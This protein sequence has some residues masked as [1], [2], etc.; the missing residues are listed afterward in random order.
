MCRR[1]LPNSELL[2]YSS[3]QKEALASSTIE[4][5]VATADELVRFQASRHTDREPV[6]EVANYSA[7]LGLGREY[8][9]SK[10]LTLNLILKLHETLMSGVRGNNLAGKFK[11]SQNF[12][13]GIGKDATFTPAAP[14]DLPGLLGNLERYINEPQDMPRVIQTAVAHYQFETIH[15]FGDGNGRV[16]RLVI[17][18]H[19][20]QLG[21]LS[22]PLI[23][24]SV[25]FERNRI[26]YY[27]ALQGV[28]D[29]GSWNAFLT[30]F[31]TG[32]IVQSKET[33]H[34]TQT[35]LSLQ[36]SMKALIK[37][38]SRQAS[39]SRVLEQFF[40]S[41]ALSIAEIVAESGMSHNTAQSAIDV[42]RKAGLVIEISGQRKR[43]IYLCQ[44]IHALIFKSPE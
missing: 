32:L 26:Q 40:K 42:L 34:F 35:C 2:I 14:E 27:E 39:V 6:R 38:V 28:R 21:L 12:I 10:P 37:G 16:G 24:P 3:L 17:L 30:Y 7:A 22:D 43:R 11:T 9:R 15:P 5:T 25:Y 41:P 13:G 1:L 4:G 36:D 23:Y 8:L 44:P 19:L 33:I 20:I 18:L 31:L 29:K